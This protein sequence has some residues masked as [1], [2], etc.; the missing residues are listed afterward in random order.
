MTRPEQLTDLHERMLE[1]LFEVRDTE[2][3]WPVTQKLGRGFDL[4]Q[5]KVMKKSIFKF[6]GHSIDVFGIKVQK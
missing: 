5:D 4:F 1:E 6:D 2:R 3:K